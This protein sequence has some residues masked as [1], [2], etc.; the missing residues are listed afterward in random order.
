MKFGLVVLLLVTSISAYADDRAA[1][2]I[3][4]LNND[5]ALE[6]A[7]KHCPSAA[8]DG[9]PEEPCFFQDG[10]LIPLSKVDRTSPYCE[11][12]TDNGFAPDAQK[13]YPMSRISSSYFSDFGYD[14][15]LKVNTGANDP[16][17]SFLIDCYQLYASPSVDDA[18][19]VLKG[20]YE[21]TP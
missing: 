16:G 8:K 15:L 17:D 19:N 4:V 11:T 18:K 5:I 3:K 6:G 2:S 12:Q 14:L 9:A 13:S 21:I 10:K 1:Y 7:L 20:I